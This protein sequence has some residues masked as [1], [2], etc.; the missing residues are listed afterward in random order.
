M[1]NTGL[2]QEVNERPFLIFHN[3]LMKPDTLPFYFWQDGDTLFMKRIIE[4][5]VPTVDETAFG[6]PAR[7]RKNYIEG[8]RLFNGKNILYRYFTDKFIRSG[9]SLWVFV[10]TNTLSNDSIEA[11]LGSNQS[12]QTF[13]KTNF[14]KNL[15]IIKKNQSLQKKLLFSPH[16][17]ENQKQM[18]LPG[19]CPDSVI[20]K[21]NWKHKNHQ[22]YRIIHAYNCGR[23]HV[24]R[25]YIIDDL[26]Q[27][28]A[29]EGKYIDIR[30][31]E[32]IDI[33]PFKGTFDLKTP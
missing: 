26:L 13:N 10:V 21:K 20:L 17:F 4:Q 9:D 32:S 28:Y 24:R 23:F 31:S 33:K 27:I 19:T 18:V 14:L 3:M 11:L 29:A 1:A 2:P 25:S 15:Q 22:L 30:L 16:M 12:S 8:S 5:Y 7:I 6:I